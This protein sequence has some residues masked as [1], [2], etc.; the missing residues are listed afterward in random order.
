MNLRWENIDLSAKTLSIVPQKT[1]RKKKRLLV[2]LH[3]RPPRPFRPP[4]GHGRGAALALYGLL[5]AGG[6]ALHRRPRG[7][8]CRIH[9]ARGRPPAS[10]SN[11]RIRTGTAGHSFVKKSFHSLWHTFNSE[12]GNKGVAP[13]LRAKLS[14]HASEE[15]M[16]HRYA[17]LEQKTLRRAVAKIAEVEDQF[18]SLIDI[19]RGRDCLDRQDKGRRNGTHLCEPGTTP[20]EFTLFVTSGFRWSER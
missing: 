11:S 9:R 8:Q 7:L 14:G 19:R 5:D 15:R 4:G 20:D 12:L 13:D 17:H 2:P 1:A 16:N 6:Q 3:P 18:F 10:T